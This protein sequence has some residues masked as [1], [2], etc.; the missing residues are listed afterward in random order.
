MT[1][2]DSFSR[3]VMRIP[4]TFEDEKEDRE[5]DELP[6][7][8]L[9]KDLL[10]SFLDDFLA[11]SLDMTITSEELLPGEETSLSF[12]PMHKVVASNFDTL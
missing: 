12:A 6:P 4:N 3:T 9:T 5:E 7:D 2:P 11:G 1:S 8:R 10:L